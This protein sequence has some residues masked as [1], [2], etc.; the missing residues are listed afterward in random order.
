MILD[1]IIILYYVDIPIILES[2][3]HL[4]W[5]YYETEISFYC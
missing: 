3:V 5:I 2:I 1:T 4:F